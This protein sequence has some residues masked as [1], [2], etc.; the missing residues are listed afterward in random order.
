MRLSEARR[1]RGA[2]PS[3]AAF[4]G[5]AFATAL[6]L[7]SCGE[8]EPVRIGFVGGLSGRSADVGEA[9]RNAVQLALEEANAAGGIGGRRIELLVRDDRGDPAA[10]AAAVRDLHA[11]GAVAIVG[12]NISAIAAGMLPELDRLRIVAVSPTVSSLA[13]A[14]RDDHLFRINWTTRDNARIYAERY[15]GLGLKRVAAAIDANNLVFSQSWLDEFAAPFAE[16]GGTVAAAEL[17]DAGQEHGYADTVRRLLSK[18]PDAIL[19]IA[20]GVDTA[21]LTQQVRKIDGGIRL[22]AAEWAASERLIFLGGSAVEGLE[23]VQSYDRNDTSERFSRFRNAYADRFSQEPG[24]ASVAG[25]D[26]ATALLAALA[27]RTGGQTV[28]DALLALAP[29]QGLQQ[30]VAFDRFGDARS[31]RSFF[32]VVREGKFATP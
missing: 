14:G 17:F 10:A 30:T 7:L 13:F 20:N 29:V 9:S 8:P 31:R 15:A 5:L 16:R 25:Y 26:A 24:Y 23:M 6:S 22:I 3:R 11:A 19:L 2:R 21:Q 12:P 1:R 4:A 27:A 18:R 32:V 28:K